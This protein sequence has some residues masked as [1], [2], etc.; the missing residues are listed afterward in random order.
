TV[1]AADSI[2]SARA[3]LL[4]G[5][6]AVAQ[7]RVAYQ[8][9]KKRFSGPRFEALAARGA[10]VQRPLWASTSTKNPA[11]PD[12]VYVDSLIGPDCVN[13]M[14]EET[15]EKFRDHGT[16]SRTVDHDPGGAGNAL[17]ELEA[18]GVDLADVA[19]TLESEGVTSFEKSFDEVSERLSNKAAQTGS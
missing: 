14:P 12:L 5:T 4:R 3:R 7:A 2:V 19:A 17:G 11:Y 10:R 16:I 9:F 18:V 13:T 6:I 8:Q 15:I 1:V